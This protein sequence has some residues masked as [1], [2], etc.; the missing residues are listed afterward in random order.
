MKHITLRHPFLAL[1]LLLACTFA[2]PAGAQKDVYNITVKDGAGKTVKL[3]Q[4]KGRV[5]LIV[6]TATR[7]GFTPQYADL[8]Q[9]YTRYH[10]QGLEILDFPCNQFG[11]QAPGSYREIHAFCTTQYA[12][13]FPQFEK[14]EVNGK[15]ASPLYTYLK[16][17]E[18]FKGFDLNTAVGKYLD[19]TFRKADPKYDQSADVKWN[20]TKFLI[21]R[22]GHVIDR[23]EPTAPL[24]SIEAGIK[25]ALRLKP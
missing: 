4:Y 21:D 13:T 20:F 24:D 23:F 15:H 1:M 9:L 11:F 12:I 14:I 17:Q 16:A 25:A 3:K 18:P 2:L 22:Q 6:N 5:L 19:D 7:C 8:Q 10:D